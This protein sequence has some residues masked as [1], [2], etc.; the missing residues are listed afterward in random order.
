MVRT[1]H[2]MSGF[3]TEPFFSEIYFG[4]RYNLKY[5]SA[6]LKSLQRD[7]PMNLKFFNTLC[8]VP[9][10]RPKVRAP[11]NHNTARDFAIAMTPH[12]TC[13]TR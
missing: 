1:L 2:K 10:K 13:T 6:T 8:G 12:G 3:S 5:G 9:L 7:R 4:N 11:S